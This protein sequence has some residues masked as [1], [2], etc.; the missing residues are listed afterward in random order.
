MNKK[1]ILIISAGLI[2]LGLIILAAF[3]IPPGVPE[4]VHITTNIEEY[5]VGDVLKVKIENNLKENICFS[6]CYPYTIEKR[7]GG[8]SSY[9]YQDC[10]GSNLNENCIDSRQ[11]KAFELVVP[12]IETGFHRLGIS[13]CI[14]CNVNEVFKEGQKLYSNDFLIK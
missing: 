12:L 7:N 6:S 10:L 9:R 2:A 11:V 3:L 5:T 4:E 8:W 1:D 14:G 13:A